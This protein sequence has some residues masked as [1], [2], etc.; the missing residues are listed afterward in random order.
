MSGG[1][2]HSTVYAGS[3]GDPNSRASG[4][5]KVVAASGGG[6]SGATV[7]SVGSVRTGRIRNF[8]Q[9]CAFAT[10][11]SSNVRPQD[12]PPPRGG[13]GGGAT[14]I[15]VPRKGVAEWTRDPSVS[16][17]VGPQSV[18]ARVSVVLVE[19][20]MDRSAQRLASVPVDEQMIAGAAFP[21]GV[22]ECMDSVNCR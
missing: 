7:C 18:P 13:G 20:T 10:R 16:T 4:G 12:P 5:G 8:A 6:D 2:R 21:A 14:R 1:S 15:T 3:G 17:S 19:E 22:A 11:I 9:I